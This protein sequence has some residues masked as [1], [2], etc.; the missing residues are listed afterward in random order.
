MTSSLLLRRPASP[1]LPA[2][3][4]LPPGVR[5]HLCRSGAV[6]PTSVHLVVP[7]PVVRPRR[8]AVP[9]ALLQR[10]GG[11]LPAPWLLTDE[12]D[13]F[14]EVAMTTDGSP[15]HVR[16]V[17]LEHPDCAVLALVPRD[18]P[19]RAVV[20]LL[21]AGADGCLRDGDPREVLAHLGAL[22][23]RTGRAG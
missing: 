20:E 21:E 19:G 4:A 18:A 22:G 23:R 1:P 10:L 13:P 7:P 14:L 16:A 2:C 17:L 11:R 9:G 12:H 5:V 6:T 8:V 3:A 15:E